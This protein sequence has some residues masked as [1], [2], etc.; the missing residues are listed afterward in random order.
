MW[1]VG[2]TTVA[3]I[4]DL[5]VIAVG[6]GMAVDSG[7]AAGG[8][9]VA[10]RSAASSPVAGGV[11]VIVFSTVNLLAVFFGARLRLPRDR[12]RDVLETFD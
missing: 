3:V 5:F 10:D 6:I 4:L 8:H 12:R 11:A 2:L 7:G 9:A 1:R